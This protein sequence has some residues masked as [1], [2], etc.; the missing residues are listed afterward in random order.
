MYRQGDVLIVPRKKPIPK[1]APRAEENGQAVLAHGEATGHSHAFPRGAQVL[2]YRDTEGAYLEVKE[3][4]APL[5]HEEH[6]TVV[7]PPGLYD[8]L[9]QT[10]YTPQELRNVAD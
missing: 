2:F 4:P 8:V 7:L 3:A 9:R 6:A 5:K 10:E 1:A